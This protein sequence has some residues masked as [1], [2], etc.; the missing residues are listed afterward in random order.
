MPLQPTE[1]RA[2]GGVSRRSNSHSRR[3]GCRHRHGFGS[4]SQGHGAAILVGPSILVL[5]GAIVLDGGRRY[6]RVF[7]G[8]FVFSSCAFMVAAESAHLKQ[9]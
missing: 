9:R 3:Y 6:D 7:D 2:L 1:R 4:H 8:S 5:L